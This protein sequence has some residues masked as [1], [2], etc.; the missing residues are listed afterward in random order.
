MVIF[1]LLEIITNAIIKAIAMIVTPT[2]PKNSRY[3]ICN[4]KVSIAPPRFPTDVTVY[5]VRWQHTPLILISYVI[6]Y[7]IFFYKKQANMVKF[8]K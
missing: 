3:I 2:N 8:Y 4:S 7:T 1:Y 5:Y 6:Y